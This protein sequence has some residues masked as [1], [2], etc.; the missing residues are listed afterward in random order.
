VATS[1]VYVRPGDRVERDVRRQDRV[2]DGRQ[3]AVLGSFSQEADER[4][5][6]VGGHARGRVLM[7]RL[8]RSEHQRQVAVEQLAQRLEPARQA[9]PPRAS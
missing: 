4:V 3:R 1:E 8:I 6:V 2:V 5:Q 7:E 9:F